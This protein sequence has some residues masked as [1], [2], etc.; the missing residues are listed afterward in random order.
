M[1][2]GQSLL[3]D[4]VYVGPVLLQQHGQLNVAPEDGIVDTGEALVILTI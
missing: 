2:D 3:I 4:G 1:N